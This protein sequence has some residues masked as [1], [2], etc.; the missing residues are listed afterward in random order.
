MKCEKCK[1]ETNQLFILEKRKRDLMVCGKCL[2]KSIYKERKK[3][4]KKYR[5]SIK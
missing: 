5:R 3:L 2:E 1:N 4:L